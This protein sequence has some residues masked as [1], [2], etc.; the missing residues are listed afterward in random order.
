MLK[1]LTEELRK[2]LIVKLIEWIQDLT[3]IEKRWIPFMQAC[4]AVLEELGKL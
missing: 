3:P 1:R 4:R 2:L